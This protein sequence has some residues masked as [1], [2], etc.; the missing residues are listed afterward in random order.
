MKNPLEAASSISVFAC[1]AKYLV[2]QAA[3]NPSDLPPD[4]FVEVE[5]GGITDQ[6]GWAAHLLNASKNIALCQATCSSMLP[7]LLFF[8]EREK[9]NAKDAKIAQRTD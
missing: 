1:P 5:E 7:F 6:G 9:K 8:F 4:P 2:T 3:P